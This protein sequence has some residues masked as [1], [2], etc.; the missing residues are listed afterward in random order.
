MQKEEERANR[1]IDSLLHQIECWKS[2]IPDDCPRR[3][4]NTIVAVAKMNCPISLSGPEIGILQAYIALKFMR[5]DNREGVEAE[6]L[7]NMTQE[8]TLL[9][10][11]EGLEGLELEKRVRDYSSRS[12]GEGPSPYVRQVASRK[13]LIVSTVVG[14]RVSPFVAG[15]NPVLKCIG[16]GRHL[17][18]DDSE[19]C[20][21]ISRDTALSIAGKGGVQFNPV[22][23]MGIVRRINE[24]TF[25]QS[26]EIASRDDKLLESLVKA[27]RKNRLYLQK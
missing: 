9:F 25:Y 16:D 13:G 22:L 19:I 2:R 5:T 8:V 18:D 24:A 1:V 7:K 6:V 23:D 21:P 14:N 15:D 3:R 11:Q 20:M 27:D 4:L 17:W 26:K 12:I 10:G